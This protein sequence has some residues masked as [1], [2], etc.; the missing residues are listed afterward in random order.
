MGTPQDIYLEFN[1]NKPLAQALQCNPPK[2][3]RFTERFINNKA[4]QVI[5]QPRKDA[6]GKGTGMIWVCSRLS[7]GCGGCAGYSL[8]GLGSVLCPSLLCSA[9]GEAGSAHCF[10]KGESFCFL[11]LPLFGI[12][13]WQG[14]V[15]L[16]WAWLPPGS[17]SR[18]LQHL[19]SSRYNFCP[20]SLM[21][22][23]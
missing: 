10:T 22:R 16:L 1:G 4:C 21:P 7:L 12:P 13:V 19:L 9:A 15:L 3:F 8:F 20:L 14:C 17:R 18:Q 6:P 2:L 11:F 5:L 23:G